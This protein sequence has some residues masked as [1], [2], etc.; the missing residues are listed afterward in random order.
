[1]LGEPT[2]ALASGFG[3]LNGPTLIER[4]TPLE[5][6]AKDLQAR[7]HEVRAQPLTSGLHIIERTPTGWR[8]GADPRR[9]GAAAGD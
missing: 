3:S 1:M 8:G 7:G 5:R 2:S 4:G 6:L 9:D